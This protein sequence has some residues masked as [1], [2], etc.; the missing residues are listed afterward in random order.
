MVYELAGLLAY[1]LFTAFP[2]SENDSGKRSKQA[3]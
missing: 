1:V 2:S 3:E